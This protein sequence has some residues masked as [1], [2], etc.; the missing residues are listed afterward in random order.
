MKIL[1]TSD[2]HGSTGR[3][4]SVVRQE[5]PDV[6]FFLGDGTREADALA[7]AMPA[8]SL[9]QVAGNCDYGSF[10]PGQGLAPLG[11]LLFFYTHGHTL[12]VKHSLDHLWH[13]AHECGADVA[14]FGHTHTPLYQ[15]REGIH[16]FN[17]GALSYARGSGPSYGVITLGHKEPIFN[18]HAL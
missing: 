13:A 8:L 2:S 7:D 16:L 17:P 9:Y 3:L 15:Q 1:V 12:G 11:G 14:L 6:C 18:I 5:K 4:F 10:A